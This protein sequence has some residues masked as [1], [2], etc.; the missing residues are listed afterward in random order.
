MNTFEIQGPDGTTYEVQAETIEQA[1][2]AVGS[3]GQDLTR[4]QK[5]K[6]NWLPDDDPNSHNRGEKVAA[7]INKAGEAMTFGLIGDEADAWAK[8][9]LGGGSYEDELA[10]NRQQEEVLER[11]NPGLAFAAEVAPAL[12]PGAGAANLMSK[13]PNLLGKVAT[14]AGIG[15]LA[16]GTYG[17]MEGEGSG[18]ERGDNAA[19]TA[20]V[21]AGV[22]A[23]LPAVGG[24]GER[25]IRNYKQRAANRKFAEAAPSIENLKSQAQR[26]YEAAHRNGATAGPEAIEEVVQNSLEELQRQ[27]LISPRGSIQ[28][29]YDTVK[30]AFNLLMDYA[31]GQMTPVQ[32][33]NVR[34][35][36]MESARKPGNE[37]RIGSLL[38]KHFDEVME[39]LA[40]Q[41]KAGNKVYARAMKAETIARLEDLA[42]DAAHAN[43]TTAGKETALRQQVR[44]L[45]KKIRSG[46]ETRFTDEEVELLKKV[47]WGGTTENLARRVG[48]AAPVSVTSAA[49]GGGM[50]FLVGNALGGPGA[51]AA[52]GAGAM[53]L[54]ALGRRVASRAQ[55]RNF[56]ALSSAVRSGEKLPVVVGGDELNALARL[57]PTG[58]IQ[59]SRD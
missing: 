8:S 39:P 40:P 7:A 50:P 30:G 31:D 43:Y 33:Q 42:D 54:G 19:F 1:A 55:N 25:V 3:L 13:A 32:M 17:F 48:T 11:D 2:Q 21:G 18:A 47:G 53:G 44:G 10:K 52:L 22:G 36:L 51:G 14:G 45:L 35:A 26:L 5:F 20:M 24:A 15:A 38:V 27:G 6:K 41:I 49:L 57:I 4:W 16:G 56:N 12:I 28:D 29:G 9:K 23:A 58:S 59:G 46:K 37:G 34:Q